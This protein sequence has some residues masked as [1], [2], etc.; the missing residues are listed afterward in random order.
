MYNIFGLEREEDKMVEFG[1]KLRD[2]RK[3]GGMT[4]KELAEKAKI[5][6]TYLSK[7]ETGVMPPPRAKTILALAEALN[8]DGD[9]R[10][11]LLGLARKIPRDLFDRITPEMI[12]MLRSSPGEIEKPEN[13]RRTIQEDKA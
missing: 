3:N 1:E 2:L 9:T 7:I 13:W 10:D 8:I 12:R 6:F 5:N 11:D 4:Q